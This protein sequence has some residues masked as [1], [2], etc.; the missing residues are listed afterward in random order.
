MN[1]RQF[2]REWLQ[3]RKCDSLVCKDLMCSCNI[4]DDSFMRCN[5]QA[6]CGPAKTVTYGIS[7]DEY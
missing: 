3:V 6:K 5:R 1:V 7:K 4:N 2:V